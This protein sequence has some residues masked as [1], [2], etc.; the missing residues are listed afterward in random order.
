MTDLEVSVR[1]HINR[2]LD[3][4]SRAVQLMNLRREL[5][6]L[7]GEWKAAGG[8]DRLPNVGAWQSRSRRRRAS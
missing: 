8:G 1:D 6:L 3:C 5:K 2:D 4:T 7:I